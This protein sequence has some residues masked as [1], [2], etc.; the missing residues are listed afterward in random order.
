MKVELLRALRRPAE[1]K[2]MGEHMKPAWWHEVL[3]MQPETAQ[4][5]LHTAA[6]LEDPMNHF[7]SI[8]AQTPKSPGSGGAPEQIVRYNLT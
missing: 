1:E 3:P 4:A 2:V 6:F 7:S 8:V 5:K